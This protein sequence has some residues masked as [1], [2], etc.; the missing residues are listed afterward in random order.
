MKRI[1]FVPLAC[2]VMHASGQTITVRDNSTR[3]PIEFVIIK[4]KNQKTATTN[5][6]GRASLNDLDKS[7]SLWVWHFSYGMKKIM[8]GNDPMEISLISKAIVLDE[9]IFSA[10]RTQEKKIDVPYKVEVVKQKDIEFGNQPTT[11]DVLLNTGNIFVQKSQLGGG[12]PNFRGFEASR[13]LMVVDGIRMNNAIYRAG[14]SQDVMTLDAQMLDRAEIIFGPSSTVYGSD[15]LGGVMHFYTKNAQFSSDDKLLVKANAMARYASVNT[16]MTGHLDLNLGFQKFASMTNITYSNFGDLTSGSVKLNGYTN[17]WDRSHY[18]IKRGEA[19]PSGQIVSGGQSIAGRDTMVLNPNDN[20]LVGSGY[21]QM[22]IMQRFRLKS[23]EHLVHDLNF[24]MSRNPKLPRYDRLAGDYSGS[25]L[26]FAENYYKQNRILGAYTLNYNGKTMISDNI[27]FILAYQ[28]IDQDRVTRRFRNNNRISQFEDVGVFSANA[29]VTKTIKEKHELRYGAEFTDNTVKST[30]ETRDIVKDSAFRA[31][32][33]YAPENKMNTFAVYLSHAYEMNENFV[34][35]EGIRFTYA[36]VMCNF[37]DTLPFK[38]PD[39]IARQNSQAVTGSLGFTWKAENDYKVSLMGNTGFRTPNVDDMSKLFE[40][41]G[42]IL[43]VANPKIKP[44]Y[45]YNF[46]L[47]ISKVINSRYKFDITG[48]YTLVENYLTLKDFKLNGQDS[49][50][51]NNTKY[52]VQAMQNSDRA[53]IYGF[54]AACQFDFNEHIS[55]KGSL[56]YTFGRYA[57]VK[58]DTVVPLDHIAPVY[59]QSSLVYKAKNTD[60]EFFSRYCGKKVLSEYSPS[61]ED[62]LQYATPDGMPGWFTL[63]IRAGYNIT[64]NLRLNLACENITDHRYRVFAS[65]INAPGRNFIVS[66]RFKM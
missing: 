44:E 61:G 13:V 55:F 41:G 36:S 63:N 28:K 50:E 40:S 64:K 5:I 51:Y 7:D 62:N 3:E 20:K 26:R 43:I 58:N 48:F 57:D 22:D 52:K 65:G 27:R 24:Q 59:G 66:L 42:G 4:D 21:R 39:P 29:D 37:S 47:G 25:N 14:H 53:Y 16:E 23:G 34:V 60:V 8:A 31:D 2:F 32:R 38:F 9:I 11:G 49:I 10:N 33:R 45:A 17:K 56:N 1:L 12:S 54:N 19:I 6:K 30:A 15:A 46:E 35:S 18:V